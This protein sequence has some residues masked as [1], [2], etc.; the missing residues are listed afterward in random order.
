MSV[1]DANGRKFDNASSL[2]LDWNL[3]GATGLADLKVKDGVE[4]LNREGMRGY[5]VREAVHPC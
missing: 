3:N 4:Y 1:L 5:R 2:N